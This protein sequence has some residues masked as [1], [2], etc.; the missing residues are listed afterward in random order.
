[1]KREVQT[2]YSYEA[3]F[4]TLQRHT[5]QLTSSYQDISLSNLR[6]FPGV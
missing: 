3:D 2:N 1:Y 6:G 4:K 5:L